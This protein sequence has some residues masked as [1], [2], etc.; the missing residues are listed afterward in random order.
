MPSTPSGFAELIRVAMKHAMLGLHVG[1]PGKV[2][3]Y[4]SD[5]ET[6]DVEPQ[7]LR[8]V[9]AED[10]NAESAFEY[11]T[12]PVIPDVPIGWQSALDGALAIT[13]PLQK[14]DPVELIFCDFDPG[15]WR[16]KGEPTTPGDL[17]SHG[18]ANAWAYPGGI[19][20]NSKKLGSGKVHASKITISGGVHL[21]AAGA[22]HP[23]PKGDVLKGTPAEKDTHDGHDHP[24]P[25]GPSGPPSMPLK[26]DALS[27]KH[28]IDE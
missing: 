5:R 21:G 28:N 19:R 22:N 17:R 1:M 10:D 3:T 23:I 18:I 4:S 20:P 26:P 8:V 24:T 15:Q 6:V 12:L 9:E 2:V 27:S 16:E 25:M 13:M 7:F 11:D 14:G